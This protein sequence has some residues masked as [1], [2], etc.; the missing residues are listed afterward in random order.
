[1]PSSRIR[2]TALTEYTREQQEKLRAGKGGVGGSRHPSTATVAHHSHG[3][4][5]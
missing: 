3:S 4:P 5:R 1:M 2:R